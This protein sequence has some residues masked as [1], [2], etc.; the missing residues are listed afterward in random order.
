MTY[1]KNMCSLKKCFLHKKKNLW[2]H[3]HLNAEKNHKYGKT[4][5]KYEMLLEVFS[6]I[7]RHLM[8]IMILTYKYCLSAEFIL[9]TK[10]VV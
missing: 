7:W 3:N 10:S 9:N 2:L 4:A 1:R 5:W 6:Q 8:D